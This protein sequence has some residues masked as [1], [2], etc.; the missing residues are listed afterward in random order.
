MDGVLK[1]LDTYHGRL[2]PDEE[3]L[4][5]LVSLIQVVSDRWASGE[6]SLKQLKLRG[7]ARLR[8]VCNQESEHNTTLSKP[9]KQPGRCEQLTAS[10]VVLVILQNDLLLC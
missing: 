4:P 1:G 2:G 7:T 9:A 5:P 8:V 3:N 10:N 6:T